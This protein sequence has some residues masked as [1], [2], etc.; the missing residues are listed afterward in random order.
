MLSGGEKQ[1]VS[2]ARMLLKR[3]KFI[4]CDE[5]TSNLDARTEHELLQSI[6]THC[7]GKT[8]L[9]IAHRLSTIRDVDKI[10]VLDAGRLAEE[11]SHDQLMESQGLY[12]ELW[13]LQMKQ[14]E[15]RGET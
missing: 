10:L 3:S 13:N 14:M 15:E 6:Q 12:A 8:C 1:R 4:V 5:A 2:I 7:E 11:G 9:F